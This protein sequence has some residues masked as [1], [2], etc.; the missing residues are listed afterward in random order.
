MRP[1][2]T[3]IVLYEKQILDQN[4]KTLQQKPVIIQF[5]Q[6]IQLFI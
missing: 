1:N 5:K 6:I 4:S 2:Y 3:I